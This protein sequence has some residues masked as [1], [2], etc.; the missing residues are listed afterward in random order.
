[1]SAVPVV[2]AQHFVLKL[3][4]GMVWLAAVITAQYCVPSTVTCT[5]AVAPPVGRLLNVTDTPDPVSCTGTLVV[6]VVSGDRLKPKPAPQ[7]V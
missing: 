1:M 7:I 6:N 4:Q 3:A 5:R 2:A